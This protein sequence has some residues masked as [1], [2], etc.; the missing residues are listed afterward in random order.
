MLNGLVQYRLEK[1][2]TILLVSLISIA[3]AL[4]GV[5]LLYCSSIF[6]WW[7]E[8]SPFRTLVQTLG[9]LLVASVAIFLMWELLIRRVFL[10]EILTKVG[11]ASNLRNT[12][13]INVSFNPEEIRWI[14]MFD[15]AK[16][17]DLF[18]TYARTWR[19]L[20]EIKLRELCSRPEVKLRLVLPNPDNKQLVAQ[21]AS[22]FGK[23]ED[24]LRQ[25][26][27]EALTDFVRLCDIAKDNNSHLS[28][29]FADVFP[30]FSYY[31]FDDIVV[32]ALYSLT[33]IKSSVPHLVADSRGTI[34][35]FGSDQFET[36]VEQ[37]TPLQEMSSEK[38]LDDEA[39]SLKDAH[40]TLDHDDKIRSK[41]LNMPFTKNE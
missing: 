22:S 36:L 27:Q 3:I 21:M 14:E 24:T 41:Q 4:F 33:K 9:S 10:D 8:H 15:K 2:R 7:P 39:V 13:L 1:Q 26:I 16:H 28:I 11:I 38:A 29:F 19:G 30:Q 34:F 32:L 6:D 5:I 40:E 20:H 18:F 17:V 12:G 35:K 31:R 23:T 25:R 37:S